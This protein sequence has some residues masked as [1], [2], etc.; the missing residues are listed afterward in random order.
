[1][2]RNREKNFVVAF[3]RGSHA[4]MAKKC[5]RKRNACAELLLCSTNLL[6]F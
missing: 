3:S 6:P 2:F 5:T 1:M 4:G